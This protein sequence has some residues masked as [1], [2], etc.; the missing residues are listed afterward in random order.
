LWKEG[1]R[2]GLLNSACHPHAEHTRGDRC[3]LQLGGCVTPV[4]HEDQP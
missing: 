1:D 3:A 4:N 2:Q